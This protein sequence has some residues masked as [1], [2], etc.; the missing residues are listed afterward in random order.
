M[1]LVSLSCKR[2]GAP[3]QINEDMEQL[4]CGH[5]G[6]QMQVERGGGTISLQMVEALGSIRTGAVQ[7]AAELA[8]VRLEKELK[9]ASYEAERLQSVLREG[10]SNLRN[11]P[12]KAEDLMSDEA[13]K[14]ARKYEKFYKECGDNPLMFS[15]WFLFYLT[16]V[17]LIIIWI[18][19][20]RYFLSQFWGIIYIFIAGLVVLLTYF[21]LESQQTK[22]IDQA[23]GQ[24]S[25]HR[26]AIENRKIQEESTSKISQ[27]NEKLPD[28]RALVARIEEEIAHN[29]KIVSLKH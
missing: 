1:N 5:C 15:N 12:F 25:R 29:K 24:L 7:T 4:A 26:T 27:A 21:Y 22:N 14:A 10:T 2:C 9:Q 3:L 6:A 8:L 20:Y 13:I 23:C 16:I 19:T 18:F 17:V 11:H 28:A